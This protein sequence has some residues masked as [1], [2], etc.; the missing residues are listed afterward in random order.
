MNTE[1]YLKSIVQFDS[2]QYVEKEEIESE[3]GHRYI[4]HD[5]QTPLP[6]IHPARDYETQL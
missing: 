6:N 4:S 2:Y 1:T 5:S 3:K